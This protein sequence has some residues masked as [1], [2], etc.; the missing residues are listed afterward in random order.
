M[1]AVWQND[2]QQ[3]EGMKMVRILIYRVSAIEDMWTT[4]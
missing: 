3:G 2:G 1:T 4:G